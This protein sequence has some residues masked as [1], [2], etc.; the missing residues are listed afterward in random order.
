M[1]YPSFSLQTLVNKDFEVP[2]H[3]DRNQLKQAL[4]QAFDWLMN[5]DFQ[6]LLQILYRADVDQELLKKRLETVEGLSAAELIAET[7]LQRQEAKV[8]IWKKYS[9][10][11][12][13]SVSDEADQW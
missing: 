7:Y 13:S 11:K 12:D 4:S 8:E 1:E 9:P 5:N 6:K 2:A 3:L 10:K